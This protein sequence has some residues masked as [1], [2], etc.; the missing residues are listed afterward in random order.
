ME[1]TPDFAELLARSRQLTSHILGPGLPHLER[2]LDQIDSQSRKLLSKSHPSQSPTTAATQHATAT[3]DTRTAYLFANRGFDPERISDVLNSIHIATAPSSTFESLSPLHETDLEGYVRHAHEMVIVGAV[4]EV[5]RAAVREF[6]EGFE[7]AGRVEWERAKRRAFEELGQHQMVG[8]S[9]VGG[10]G[11]GFGSDRSGSQVMGNLLGGSARRESVQLEPRVKRYAKVIRELNEARLRGEDYGLISQLREVSKQLDR[12]DATQQHLTECWTHLASILNETDVLHGRFQRTPLK[13][14]Q[15]AVAVAS[16]DPSLRKMLVAGGRRSLQQLFWAYAENQVQQHRSAIGGRPTVSSIIEAYVNVRMTQIG[17]WK[18]EWLERFRGVPFWAHLFYLIRAGFVDVAR[19]FVESYQGIL[20]R[21]DDAKFGMYFTAWVNGGCGKL[22]DSLRAQIH[23]EYNQRVRG[24]VMLDANGVWA[25]GDAFKMAIYKI[26]GRC[27]LSKRSLVAEVVPSIEDYLWLQLMLVSEDGSAG[28]E[29]ASAKYSLRDMSAAMQRFGADHFSSKG[30]TPVIWFKTLLLC[31]EF[32]RAVEY[33]TGID[34]VA[35]DAVHFATALAYYGALRVPENPHATDVG[36]HLLSVQAVPGIDPAK[37]AA[38]S[39][40]FARL[41]H[42][43]A[44]SFLGTEP[45]E[46]LQYVYLIG[47]YGA[48]LDSDGSM[49]DGGAFSGGS[50]GRDYT[51]VC[52]TYVRDIARGSGD[53]ATLFGKPR[54]GTEGTTT[55]GEVEKFGRLIHIRTH[56]EFLATMVKVAAEQADRDGKFKEAVYLYDLAA[57]YN[58]VVSILN[59]HLGEMMGQQRFAGGEADGGG[60]RQS[61]GGMD[62]GAGGVDEARTAVQYAE[63][64]IE[65]YKG[66]ATIW[67]T[68]TAGRKRT[69]EVLL[70]LSKFFRDYGQGKLDEALAGMETLGLIPLEGSGSGSSG[71]LDMGMIQRKADEFGELDEG[72]GVTFPEVLVATMSV[73]Q[74]LYQRVGD[75]GG[76]DWVRSERRAE[77]RG[78]ATRLMVFAGLIQFRIPTDTFA[79]LTRMDV[80]MR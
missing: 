68:I 5:R 10:G 60:R 26:V 34:G 42:Q 64:V 4:E 29:P 22:Q 48:E 15:Y 41:M 65:Y 12:V 14:K 27:E 72:V 8:G 70:S 25:G 31:G 73:L 6:E 63:E 61:Y 80:M 20:E 53:Y 47:L 45:V 18:H 46:A 23:G 17:S 67:G 35:I 3:T 51:R 36:M 30:K 37:Y 71:A 19:E 44:K 33:L 56:E 11:F 9:G 57:D 54:R 62:I 21:T 52:H 69:V 59:R 24:S 40:S 43:Y 55:A 1:S 76:E 75:K 79:Q 58:T 2:G 49:Q 78:K 74:K 38:A 16:S 50:M 39:L 13:E 32:E 28:S 7:R 66:Y 77:L